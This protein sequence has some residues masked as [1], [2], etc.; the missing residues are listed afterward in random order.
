MNL[1]LLIYLV[2]ILS[3]NYNKFIYS[4]KFIR[5]RARVHDSFNTKKKIIEIIY[6]EN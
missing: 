2:I 1:F 4:M 5:V 3:S 6:L